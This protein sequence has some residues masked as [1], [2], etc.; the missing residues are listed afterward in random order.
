MSGRLVQ[1]CCRVSGVGTSVSSVRV[2]QGRRIR[3]DADMLS[4]IAAMLRRAVSVQHC[5]NTACDVSIA[6]PQGE[7][8]LVSDGV[9]SQFTV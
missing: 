7:H 2:G 6:R 5:E 8:T 9:L 1:C 3:R 4:Q